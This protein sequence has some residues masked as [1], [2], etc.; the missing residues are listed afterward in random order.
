MNRTPLSIGSTIQAKG[1]SS[2]TYIIDRVIGDGASSIVYEAHYIDNAYGRH[3]TRIKECYP[4]ASDI[5]RIGTELVWADATA[6]MSDKAAFTTAYHMLLDFQNTSNLRNS[7]AHIFDLCEANGTL[8]SVMDVNE[9]QTFDQDNSKKLSDI[10]KTTLALARVVE[11]YHNKGYLHLDIKPSNFLVIPETRELVILFDVDSVTLISDIAS[12]KVKCVS[13]S[14][15]WAAPEQMQGR[16]DKICPATDIYSI[17]AI[18]FQK[19]MGRAVEN[20]DIGIFA[21]WN[22]NRE[23]LSGTNPKIKRLLRN[24]FC[25]TLA[26]NSKRRYQNA[27]ELIEALEHAVETVCNEKAYIISR[28]PSCSNYFVGRESELWTLHTALMQNS[29]LIFVRGEGGIGKSELV[30]KYL[31]LYS[32]CFD[33]ISFV[34]YQNS[35]DDAINE[36][37]IKHKDEYSNFFDALKDAC[38]ENTLIVLDNFD[39]TVDQATDLNKLISLN[40][41]IIVTTRT[42]FSEVYPNSIYINLTGLGYTNLKQIFELNSDYQLS[43]TESMQLQK[44]FILGEGCTYY[45][46]LI[47]KLMK[48]GMYNVSEIATMVLH[49]IP[50]LE[51]VIVSKDDEIKKQTI[52]KALQELFRLSNLDDYQSELFSFLV[53]TKKLAL[54]KR[55]LFDFIIQHCPQ[56]KVK[57]ADAINTLV[58]LG[59]VN[60]NIDQLIVSDVLCDLII[61]S[62][63]PLLKQNSLIR[64][65]IEEEFINSSHV[66]IEFDDEIGKAVLKYNFKCLFAVFSTIST[67]KSSDMV[68]IVDS[69]FDLLGGREKYMAYVWNNYSKYVFKCIMLVTKN[70][71]YEPITRIK[72]NC[73]I[74]T[75]TVAQTSFGWGEEPNDENREMM[76]ISEALFHAATAIMKEHNLF[77]SVI[78]DKLCLPYMEISSQTKR[79]EMIDDK[80][81]DAI[82]RLNPTNLKSGKF[83]EN[84][85]DIKA[86]RNLKYQKYYLKCVWDRIQVC[87]DQE[88]NRY[89]AYNACMRIFMNGPIAAH[90]LDDEHFELMENVFGMC[91]NMFFDKDVIVDS[92]KIEIH[93]ELPMNV[94]VLPAANIFADTLWGEDENCKEQDFYIAASKDNIENLVSADIDSYPFPLRL[95][96]F[97]DLE[98]AFELAETAPDTGNK[99]R[100]FNSWLGYALDCLD[101]KKYIEDCIFSSKSNIL[102]KMLKECER[103]IALSNI[104]YDLNYIDF[105]HKITVYENE[106]RCTLRHS[107]VLLCLLGDEEAASQKFNTL[108]DLSKEYLNYVECE[109]ITK[110]QNSTVDGDVNFWGTINRLS[111]WGYSK[112]AL[113]F[114]IEYVEYVRTHYSINEHD[115]DDMY[116]LYGEIVDLA[117]KAYEEICPSKEQ[118]LLAFVLFPESYP[119]SISF[120]DEYQDIINKYSKKMREIT[121]SKYGEKSIELEHN[122]MLRK[123]KYLSENE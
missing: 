77:D 30:K 103:L 90:F 32:E 61:T 28:Y 70:M 58:E 117:K 67:Q 6:A 119:G 11:K 78:I 81:I 72:A 36:I 4:Y 101:P 20:E 96:T 85:F 50:D 123:F 83:P 7:T 93:P 46:E 33:A 12:G 63:E 18:L 19:V 47:A 52:F 31:E 118:Q 102:I 43:S 2:Y 49:G 105:Y 26:A 79:F 82:I 97:A 45:V 80:T 8:Y 5:Q 71:V 66:D 48:R 109:D 10:L 64:F 98:K 75:F 35:F 114:L 13:Y 84:D 94:F 108:M 107:I 99:L 122:K 24:I 68:Y 65:F 76:R 21:D 100:K 54:T 113:P 40:A 27:S 34:R 89:T 56:K 38:N 120:L 25:K 87:N 53:G 74:S 15:G 62:Q 69:L 92:K 17:G 41:K 104:K 3:D 1:G 9:G 29:S 14:K 57:Y 116:E 44:V 121:H 60:Y 111:R 110:T 22:M 88:E 51:N 55:Q 42:D 91:V 59:Y 73:I 37:S 115:E 23:I 39:V 112:F 95:N 106:Y 16:I 86:L